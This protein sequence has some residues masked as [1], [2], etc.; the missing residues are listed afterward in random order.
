M[1][2]IPTSSL[3]VIY[4]TPPAAAPG[5]HYDIILLLLNYYTGVILF[6]IWGCLYS[7]GLCAL[8]HILALSLSGLAKPPIYFTHILLT[9]AMALVEKVH[10]KFSKSGLVRRSAGHDVPTRG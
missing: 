3:K 8:G 2:Y 5:V 10:Y 1:N 9:E 7:L 4:R 6:S